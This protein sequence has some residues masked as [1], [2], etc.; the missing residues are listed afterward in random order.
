MARQCMGWWWLLRLGLGD[1]TLT[2]SVLPAGNGSGRKA[3]PVFVS[4]WCLSKK[5]KEAF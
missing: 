5:L 2:L 3:L 1:V 4:T